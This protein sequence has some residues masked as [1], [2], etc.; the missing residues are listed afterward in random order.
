[1]TLLVACSSSAIQ[2]LPYYL[3][4]WSVAASRHGASLMKGEWLSLPRTTLSTNPMVM[5]KPIK[6]GLEYGAKRL[7]LGYF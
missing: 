4:S 2:S 5:P 6:R 3:E 7:S 1:M